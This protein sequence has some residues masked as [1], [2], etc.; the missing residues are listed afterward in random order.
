MILEEFSTI[1]DRPEKIKKLREYIVDLAVRGKL[2]KQNEDDKSINIFIE[3]VKK[4][5]EQLIKNKKIKR[6]KKLLG[7]TEN[8]IPYELPQNW[9][10]VRLG[11]ISDLKIGKTPKREVKEY[12][13]NGTIPW[14]SISDMDKKGFVT[15]TKEKVSI[16]A[17][18]KEFKN[19]ISPKGTLIMSFKLS[20][21]KVGILDM[22]SYHNEA[23]VSILPILDK[24][25]ILKMYLFSILGGIDLLSDTKKAIKGK[26]LNKDTLTNLLIPLPPFEEQ[27]R[28][29]DKIN[30][31]MKICDELENKLEENLNYIYLT[32]KST[33]N[34]INICKN[35][36]EVKEC[37]SFIIEHFEDLSLSDGAVNKIK[38]IILSLAVQGKLVLQDENDEPASVLLEKIKKEKEQLKKENKLAREIKLPE[39]KEPEDLYEIPKSWEWAYFQDITSCITCGVASTPKYVEEGKMFLSAKNVK[40][41]KFM[42]E[43]H[44]FITEELFDKITKNAKPMKNDILLTRVGAGIGEATIIDQDIE[45]AIY[46]SLTLIKPIHKYI[47]SKYIL[48]FLNSSEGTKK[49]L[50]NTFG[51]GASQ[52]NLNVNQVR[53]FMIPIPPLEEQ[54]RIVEKID[55]LMLLCDKLEKEI[56]NSKQ[57]N[58]M[59]M[60]KILNDEISK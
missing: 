3:E 22:D 38:N 27:K 60:V 52:G 13:E 29:V 36:K 30:Y 17:S 16:L 12:W 59:L 33:L 47:N 8:D 57:L 18:E 46:V 43:D 26:T 1:F 9:R 45:F 5:K 35:F 21:G 7:I 55:S 37:L 53:K 49:C 56:N 24:N 51:K 10:W 39:V 50:I 32:T 44:K 20:I 6:N 19:N 2:V 15:S 48:Y 25:E 42:P 28:I 31:F 54:N 11:D 34:K 23:I 4:E 40:P 14:V 58:E 41:Y